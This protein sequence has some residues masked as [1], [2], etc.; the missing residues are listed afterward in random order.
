MADDVKPDP[1]LAERVS[2]LMAAEVGQA[3]RV[4]G[5]SR[6]LWHRWRAQDPAFAA[7]AAT[8]RL[9]AVRSTEPQPGLQ[10]TETPVRV[11]HDG[12]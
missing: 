9:A 6:S 5:I 8:A 11:R 12:R 2:A 3:A 7:A 4:L 1:A 10:E